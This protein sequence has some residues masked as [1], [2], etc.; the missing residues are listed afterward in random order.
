[1]RRYDILLH[2]LAR[3]RNNNSLE[4]GVAST[5]LS[6]LKVIW[7]LNTRVTQTDQQLTVGDWCAIRRSLN[8][9]DHV[10]PILEIETT[11]GHHVPDGLET[12]RGCLSAG[13]LEYD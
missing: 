1:M 6:T 9:G 13:Q 2:E 10:L 3:H 5:A 4:P 7:V 12:D 11:S 8:Q